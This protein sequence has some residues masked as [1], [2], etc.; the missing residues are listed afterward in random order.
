MAKSMTM[1][2]MMGSKSALMV[3]ALLGLFESHHVMSLDQGNRGLSSF[4]LA[5]LY[6]LSYV[7]GPSCTMYIAR[8][9]ICDVCTPSV[10]DQILLFHTY[11]S[12]ALRTIRQL[13]KKVKDFLTLFLWIFCIFLDRDFFFA[14]KTKFSIMKWIEVCIFDAF[15]LEKNSAGETLLRRTC[16]AF[17]AFFRFLVRH[18]QVVQL[19]FYNFCISEFL[20]KIVA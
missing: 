11:F 14:C 7:A 18:L 1:A 5:L 3:Q 8:T 10:G 2:K 13:K 16:V 19:S 6:R 17:V 15:R 20:L 4:H 12:I 9:H